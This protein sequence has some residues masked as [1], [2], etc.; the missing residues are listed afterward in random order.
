MFTSKTPLPITITR[1]ISSL[2]F[3]NLSVS[4]FNLDDNQKRWIVIGICLNKIL[5]APL[6]DFVAK[7]I[8]KHYTA[9]Q[10]AHKIDRQ[11]YKNFLASDGMFEFN[12]GSINSNWDHCRRK[13]ASYNYNV[14]SPEEFAKL[15]LEPIMAKFT[16][17]KIQQYKI[18]NEIS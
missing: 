13:K 9:L 17:K 1:Y 10:T 4:S 2:T 7:K 18:G 3:F 12:Y 5:L 14:S 15:Y 6:R 16:G 11:V 8:Q